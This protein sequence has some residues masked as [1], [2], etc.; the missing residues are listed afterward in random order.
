MDG[1]DGWWT[2]SGKIRLPPPLLL[3]SETYGRNGVT[4]IEIQHRFPPLTMINGVGRQQQVYYITHQFPKNCNL[5]TQVT[6]YF[7]FQAYSI[8]ILKIN[9]ILAYFLNTYHKLIKISPIISSTTRLFQ[10]VYSRSG[11]INES[12]SLPYLLKTYCYLCL[13]Q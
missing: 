12:T 8:M 1:E 13:G 6:L 5:S 7:Y 2:T 3:F 9:N 4:P 11:V 10:I